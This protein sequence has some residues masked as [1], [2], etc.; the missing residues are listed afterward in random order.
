MDF[1]HDQL[2]DGRRFRVFAAVDDFTRKSLV[3][4]VGTVIGRRTTDS[5]RLRRRFRTINPSSR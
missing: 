2:A 3:L 1:V 5:R 4:R